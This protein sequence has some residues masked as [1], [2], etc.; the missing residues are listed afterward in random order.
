MLASEEVPVTNPPCCELPQHIA[1][2]PDVYE[3]SDDTYLFVDTL[4][5]DRELINAKQPLICLEVG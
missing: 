4:H 1:S 3:P 2:H 5:L